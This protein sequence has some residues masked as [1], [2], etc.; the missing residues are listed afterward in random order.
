MRE[1]GFAF[2][3]LLINTSP[4]GGI[5]FFRLLHFVFGLFT[6]RNGNYFPFSQQ[7]SDVVLALRPQYPLKIANRLKLP[8][9]KDADAEPPAL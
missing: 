6:Y 4:I 5:L 1:F 3:F 2:F 8:K 9:L 7:Q